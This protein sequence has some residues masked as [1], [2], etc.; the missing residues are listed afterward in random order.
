M[1]NGKGLGLVDGLKAGDATLANRLV[2]R[3][4]GE[5]VIFV[6][7]VRRGLLFYYMILLYIATA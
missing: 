3:L 2:I 1:V 6:M 4:P 7:G 5:R